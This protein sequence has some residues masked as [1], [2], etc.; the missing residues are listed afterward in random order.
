MAVCALEVTLTV[1]SK[2]MFPE[3]TDDLLIR[4]A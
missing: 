2:V 4:M 1:L 3:P